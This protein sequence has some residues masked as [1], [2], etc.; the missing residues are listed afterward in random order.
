VPQAQQ[1]GFVAGSILAVR[2][3]ARFLGLGTS[4]R[5]RKSRSGVVHPQEHL[6]LSDQARL[7]RLSLTF[8]LFKGLGGLA[9]GL[10]HAGGGSKR[11]LGV[12]A[13]VDDSQP[14]QERQFGEF[15]FNVERPPGRLPDDGQ[16]RY[17]PRQAT[18]GKRRRP[19]PETAR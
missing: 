8:G 18:E 10:A 13:A 16:L 4:L 2:D 1:P 11:C 7:V 19:C 17:E 9:D 3:A 12:R 15:G 6:S 5:G 14:G